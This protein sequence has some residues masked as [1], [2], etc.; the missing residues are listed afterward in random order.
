MKRNKSIWDKYYTKE[1]KNYK[2]PDISM[3]D[4][5]KRIIIIEKRK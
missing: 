5:L 2:F 1:E 3:Y 4:L